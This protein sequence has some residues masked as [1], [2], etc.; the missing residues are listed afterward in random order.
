MILQ[1]ED[2][3]SCFLQ[4]PDR[5][6][7]EF[8]RELIVLE[9]YRQKRV[10]SGKAAELLGTEKVDFIRHASD[11]GIPYLDMT[12]DE[13]EAEFGEADRLTLDCRI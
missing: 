9:L 13:L 10:S 4:T 12:P 1:I 2:D 5:S 6:A 3:L 7:E 8:A 11:F